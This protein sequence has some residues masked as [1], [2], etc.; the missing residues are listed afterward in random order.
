MRANRGTSTFR[1][2]KKGDWG[3][4]F[5]VF[6]PS[7]K[8]NGWLPRHATGCQRRLS[9]PFADPLEHRYTLNFVIRT[10]R[11]LYDIER[12]G[13][14]KMKIVRNA[15]ELAT[16]LD[17]G[18]FAMILHFEGVEAIDTDLNTLHL[19]YQAGLRSVG[20]A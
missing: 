16:C 6:T 11:G 17:D 15:E 2:P 18:T 3:A 20:I 10:L 12:Q 8:P 4:A 19:F 13:K 9:C 1:V 5:A 7:P 14:G